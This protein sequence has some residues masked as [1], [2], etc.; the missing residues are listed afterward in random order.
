MSLVPGNAD[1]A[2]VAADSTNTHIEDNTNNT[3]K[4]FSQRLLRLLLV[5]ALVSLLAY[6]GENASLKDWSSSIGSDPQ[7]NG[8]PS[9]SSNSGNTNT[10]NNAT[11]DPA[12]NDGSSSSADADANDDLPIPSAPPTVNIPNG[13]CIVKA[14]M[15]HTGNTEEIVTL[16]NLRI[17]ESSK[18]HPGRHWV[19]KQCTNV[20]SIP[21]SSTVPY[22]KIQVDFT[23]IPNQDR[24]AILGFGGAFTEASALNYNS[25]SDGGK[26]AVMELL[27][28]VTGLGYNMGRV[29]MNSCDFCVKSYSFADVDGDFDLEHF[30]GSVVHDVET[31]MVGMMLDADSKLRQSWTDENEHG[32]HLV[33]SPWSPP[34][35]MKLPVSQR[36]T[37]DDH[38]KTMDGSTW[39]SCLRGGTGPGT[40]YADTWGLYFSKFLTAYKDLG[41]DIWA[42]TVQNEPEFPAPWEACVY[43]PDVEGDF[44]AYHLGPKLSEDHPD[45]KLLIFDHNKDHGPL[46]MSNLLDPSN[47]AAKYISGTGLHWYAGGM[48]RLL[49]GAVGTPNMH[50]MAAMNQGNDAGH[51][52]LGTEACHCPST[53]YAGGDVSI[54]WARAERYAHTVLADLAAGSNGWIEWNLV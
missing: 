18:M 22:A 40:R 2:V 7:Q 37:G 11:Q 16:D 21:V 31:G 54:G 29:H 25:L 19:P 30:D 12:S 23:S 42:V 36:L 1:S 53:Y 49:D 28:G 3:S 20:D 38:A 46:W 32:L 17:L 27:F 51:I 9:A 33:A 44:I 6:A 43:T 35:W 5:I 4:T 45:V 13:S 41:I 52:I 24:P 48:D 50:K 14:S 26:E 47:P 39:P 34:A 15:S 8:D 10:S